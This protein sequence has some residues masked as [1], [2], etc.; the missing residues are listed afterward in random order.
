MKRYTNN[1]HPTLNLTFTKEMQ[2]EIL[3]YNG[4]F[5]DNFGGYPDY[6]Q[7]DTPKLQ[8]TAKRNWKKSKP[9]V[10]PRKLTHRLRLIVEIYAEKLKRL[11]LTDNVTS[12]CPLTPMTP[13]TPGFIWSGLDSNFRHG[14][15]AG[16]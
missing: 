10:N 7:L 15:M 4:F 8:A 2:T 16:R 9:L 11:V 1:P 14:R 13:L 3:A 5:P 12:T 6:H